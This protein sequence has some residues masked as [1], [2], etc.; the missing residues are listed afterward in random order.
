MANAKVFFPYAPCPNTA[1]DCMAIVVPDLESP[2]RSGLTEIAACGTCDVH[3]ANTNSPSL[4]L[5]SKKK[6]YQCG[7]YEKTTRILSRGVSVTV[8]HVCGVLV[9]NGH[10]PELC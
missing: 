3:G 6:V 5:N 2:E 8:A 7:R 4:K 1:N 9:G 10:K